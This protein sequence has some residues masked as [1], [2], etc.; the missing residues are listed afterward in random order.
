MKNVIKNKRL[1]TL[2]SVFVLLAVSILAVF[3]VSASDTCDKYGHR[4]T[5]GNCI[6]C[7][8]GCNHEVVSGTGYC[9][10]CGSYAPSLCS[11]PNKTSDGMHCLD[12][13]K[14]FYFEDES[15]EE[16]S[17]ESSEEASG[18]SSF[19]TCTHSSTKTS[20]SPVTKKSHVAEIRCQDCNA[21]IKFGA[22]SD[23]IFKDDKSD[24]VC[25]N[26]FAEGFSF[27]I[28]KAAALL[29]VAVFVVVVIVLSVHIK[30]KI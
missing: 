15:T 18:E 5:N 19:P 7:G 28:S 14:Y 17:E 12:C 22:T 16:S 30:K 25:G 11:H 27:D 3:S 29:F 26:K 1:L 9:E 4:W 10:T 24:C 6:E 20:Y 23:C 13:G 2:F 21:L 8:L